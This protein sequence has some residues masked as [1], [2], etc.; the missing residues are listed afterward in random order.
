MIIN[1]S[2]GSAVS[3]FMRMF[4]HSEVFDHFTDGHSLGIILLSA[5]LTRSDDEPTLKLL[6]PRLCVTPSHIKHNRRTIV[7]TAQLFYCLIV[8]NI[9]QKITKS[10]EIEAWRSLIIQ[11]V[12]LSGCCNIIDCVPGPCK[13]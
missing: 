5:N 2:P 9:S 13:F 6:Y 1:C 10:K 12:R 3:W 11:L 8:Q 4:S 7:A